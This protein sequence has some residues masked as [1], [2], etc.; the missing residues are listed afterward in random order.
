[1]KKELYFRQQYGRIN[2][3]KTAVLQF[4]YSISSYP[5]L[6]LEVFLRKNFGERYFSLASGITVACLLAA[7]PT[8]F[9]VFG[10]DW[11][12]FLLKDLSLYLFI[13]VFLSRCFRHDRDQRRNPSVFDFAK[14]SLY[15]GDVHP[16]F[17]DFRLFGKPTTRRIEIFLEP[18]PFFILGVALMLLQQR[19]G[20][21]LTACSVVYCLSYA[22]AYIVGDHYVMDMIDQIISNEEMHKT[23]VE[24]APPEDTRGFRVYGRKPVEREMREKLVPLMVEQSDSV[25]VS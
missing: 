2:V 12:D 3:L 18:L 21:V 24:D 11:R 10:Y 23:F 13:A 17:T 6:L 8:L 20:I 16:L 14:F 19:L 7:F 1:M 15:S 22:G 4:V 5:R 25:E 9:M